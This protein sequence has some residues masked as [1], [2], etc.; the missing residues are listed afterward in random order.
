M[1]HWAIRCQVHESLWGR[2]GHKISWFLASKE[3][4]SS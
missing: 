1:L 3:G 4:G 2:K